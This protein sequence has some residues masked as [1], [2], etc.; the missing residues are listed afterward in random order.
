MNTGSGM[1]VLRRTVLILARL[2]WSRGSTPV[3]LRAEARP[4]HAI[5]ER[6]TTDVQS[7]LDKALD[8]L[9]GCQ[10]AYTN[11]LGHLRRQ[12]NQALFL[13]LHIHD[14]DID[15]ADIAEPIRHPRHTQPRPRTRR[16]HTARAHRR[17]GLTGRHRRS[18]R[19]R[20]K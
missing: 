8:L 7:T 16:R 9:T 14:N 11:A 2:S 15:H 12:W 17:R 1:D 3:T 19:P 5:A 18:Q 13:R 20:F 4:L 6:S 10:H